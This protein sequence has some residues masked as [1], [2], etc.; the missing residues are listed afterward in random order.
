MKELNKFLKFLAWFVGSLVA[1]GL[2]VFLV[3]FLAKSICDC[4]STHA[5]KMCELSIYLIAYALLLIG[6]CPR[7]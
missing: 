7:K 5:P 1:I 3:V 2:L 6:L 4:E